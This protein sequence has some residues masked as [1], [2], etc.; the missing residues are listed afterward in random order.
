MIFDVTI[1]I[2]LGS[3]EP[4]PGKIGN[5]IGKYC[6]VQVL[7]DLPNGLSPVSLPLL[8]SPYP[9]KHKVLKSGQLITLQWPLNV[10]VKERLICV[11]L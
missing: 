3:H 9:L 7:T 2:V 4:H 6:A 8:R 11:L 5:L 1:V 10:Q